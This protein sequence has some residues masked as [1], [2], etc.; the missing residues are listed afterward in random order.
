MEQ[1][2]KQNSDYIKLFYS[3]GQTGVGGGAGGRGRGQLCLG[4][5]THLRSF[6]YNN[7]N[8]RQL[9][10]RSKLFSAGLGAKNEEQGSKTARKMVVV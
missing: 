4:Q 2:S 7:S 8:S 6:F 1:H 9:S 3:Q 10:P 5:S